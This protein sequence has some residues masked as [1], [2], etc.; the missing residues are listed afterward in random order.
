M[1]KCKPNYKSIK[2]MLSVTPEMMK[3][4]E[5]E[6]ENL[7][8]SPPGLFRLCFIILQKNAQKNKKTLFDVIGESLREG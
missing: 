1:E 8:I 4:I 3:D 2:I 6:S 5:K 7:G